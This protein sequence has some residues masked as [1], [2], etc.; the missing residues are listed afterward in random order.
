MCFVKN[1]MA[2]LF[3]S[4][5][6]KSWLLIEELVRAWESWDTEAQLLQDMGCTFL[7]SCKTLKTHYSMKL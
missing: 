6:V 4:G 5:L 1:V 3:V 7:H 2:H